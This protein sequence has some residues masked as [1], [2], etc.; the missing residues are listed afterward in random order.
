MSDLLVLCYHGV[1][2]GWP[3]DLAVTP[4]RMERQ[5]ESLVN[6]GYRGA[7]FTAAVTERSH[8]HTIVVTFDDGYSSVR[9][10]AAPILARLGLPG[11]VFVTTQFVGSDE[12]M[13]WPGIEQ[14]LNGQWANELLPMDEGELRALADSGWE[15]G[16]HTHTHPYLP[17]LTD[18]AL[19]EEMEQ[20]KQALERVLQRTCSAVAYPY[21]AWDDR[22]VRAAANAGYRAGGTLPGRLHAQH[23]LSW[24]RVYVGR[25]DGDSRFFLK[26]YPIFRWTRSTPVW[27]AVDAARARAGMN[28]PRRYSPG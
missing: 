19:R 26:V 17:E 14:W 1:S 7:T 9:S 8:E 6:R 5:L 15:V 24:P 4:E 2:E 3:S 18:S 13:S 10:L 22:V 11:T 27:R 12:P 25:R 23:P 16:S 21:G 28:D 20:S